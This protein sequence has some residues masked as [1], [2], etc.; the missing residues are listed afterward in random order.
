MPKPYHEAF[1]RCRRDGGNGHRR[2]PLAGRQEISRETGKNQFGSPVS[3]S[4]SLTWPRLELGIRTHEDGSK[5]KIP[6]GH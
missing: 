6:D 3:L 2:L 1:N 5:R 4:P